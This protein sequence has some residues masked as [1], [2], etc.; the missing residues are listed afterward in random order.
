MAHASVTE[1]LQRLTETRTGNL[2]DVGLDHL[3]V[4][5]GLGLQAQAGEL[6][7]LLPIS[8]ESDPE[9]AV[10]FVAVPA[11]VLWM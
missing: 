8:I 1:L 3:G 11:A 9:V 5:V 10:T 7:A 4:G 6:G 2:G